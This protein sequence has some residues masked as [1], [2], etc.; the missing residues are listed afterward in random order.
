[1]KLLDPTGRGNVKWRREDDKNTE[2][3]RDEKTHD[4]LL[5]FLLFKIS[6]FFND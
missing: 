1:M 3:E 5:R 4:F 2:A 6:G